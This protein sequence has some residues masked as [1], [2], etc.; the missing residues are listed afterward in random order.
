MGPDRPTGGGIIVHD[1]E[2]CVKGL[3]GAW[4][5]PEQAASGDRGPGR[6][7]WNTS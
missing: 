4:R 3:S 2:S 5:V 1:S 7:L 6:A